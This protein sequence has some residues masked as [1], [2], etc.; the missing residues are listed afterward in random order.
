[1]KESY[2]SLSWSQEGEDL[3][4]GRYFSKRNGTFID[5]GA[6]HPYRYSNTFKFYRKGWRGLNIDPLPN[7]KSL[8]DQERPNDINI[9]CAISTKEGR[10]DYYMF[11]L[12]QLNTFSKKNAEFQKKKWTLQQVKSMDVFR[13][14]QILEKINFTTDI[15]LFSIDVEGLELEVLKSNDWSKY[16][17][18]VIVIENLDSDNKLIDSYLSELNY[19]QF[20]NTINSYFYEKM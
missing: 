4:L 16:S 8:F 15:D 10:A 14:D 17:P 13:L 1:M 20:A 19:R 9:E 6:H 18:R 7:M 11:E 5:V 3:I 12:P 2:R